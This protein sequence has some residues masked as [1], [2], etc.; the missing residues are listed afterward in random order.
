[1]GLFVFSRSSYDNKCN[2]NCNCNCNSSPPLKIQPLNPDPENWVIMERCE[3][4]EFLLIRI[5]YPNCTNYEGYKILLYKNCTIEELVQQRKIDPHFSENKN[6]KSPI[7]RFVP[8]EEGWK[9]GLELIEVLKE[10][11]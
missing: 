10:N 11:D 7:A 8:T 6:F 3:S 2:C 5:K 1:M 9:M 4:E